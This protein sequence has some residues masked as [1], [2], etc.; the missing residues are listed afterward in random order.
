MNESDED[1]CEFDGVRFYA[2]QRLL[3]RVRDRAEFFIRPKE[4][5]FLQLLLRRPKQT[6][7]YEEFREKVWPDAKD[8]KVLLPTLRETK[9]TLDDLLGE[10][11]KRPGE[12]IETVAKR[13]YRLNVEIKSPVESEASEK[14]AS[15]ERRLSLPF[16]GHG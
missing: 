12:I 1:F 16:G 9:R 15:F 10:I 4:R 14:E 2:Q 5:D 7:L 13:G 8:V 3:L 11:T 6:V